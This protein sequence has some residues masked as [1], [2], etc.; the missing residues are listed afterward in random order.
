[1]AKHDNKTRTKNIQI[2][3]AVKAGMGAS[4]TGTVPGGGSGTR[5]GR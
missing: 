4:G 5:R 3:T 2:H 1:M